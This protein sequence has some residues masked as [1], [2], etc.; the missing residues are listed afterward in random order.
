MRGHRVH[1]IKRRSGLC[2]R[3]DTACAYRFWLSKTIACQNGF[4]LPEPLLAKTEIADIHG[5]AVVGFLKLLNK[6]SSNVQDFTKRIPDNIL[7]L[8]WFINGS[9]ANYKTQ[10]KLKPNLNPKSKDFAEKLA[11]QL[12]Q[13]MIDA[14]TPG[15]PSLID[16]RLP[17]SIPKADV[18][19]MDYFP[20]YNG[21]SPEQRHKYLSWLTDIT[22]P[23][24][25]GYVFV[26]HYGLE[27]HLLFGDY[28]NAFMTIA[29][30]QKYHDNK[31]FR[32]YSSS[33]ML[34]CILKHQRQD[35][36]EHLNLEY[37]DAKLLLFI[38]ALTTKQITA[39]DIMCSCRQ[40][41]FT[42]KR[43]I[44]SCPELFE[45]ELKSVLLENYGQETYPIHDDLRQAT[46]AFFFAIANYSLK[47]DERSAHLPDITTSP[48][49]MKELPAI[50]KEAHNRTKAKV[51]QARKQKEGE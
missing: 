3:A 39:K 27:R 23:I 17:I 41:G 43:Y 49:L 37:V 28:E 45:A 12:V 31:S 2:V 29:E 26:F 9:M 48:R 47:L 15:E 42:N 11:A 1:P 13:G 7:N 18:P 25:I 32:L 4:G 33:A 46:G 34:V 50:L 44:T 5:G 24:N 16:I 38:L 20:S 21:M 30:L 19:N 40:V 36:L 8:L 35:L 10:R 22:H 14:A 6:Q 51:T